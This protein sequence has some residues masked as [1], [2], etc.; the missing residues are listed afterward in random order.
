[1]QSELDASEHDRILRT[2]FSLVLWFDARGADAS[3]GNMVLSNLAAHAYV[4]LTY[5]SKWKELQINY[6]A[7]VTRSQFEVNI[8]IR[9]VLASGDNL[10]RFAAEQIPDTREV[11]SC[12]N[13]KMKGYLSSD[14]V[15]WL[16][17]EAAES[18]TL[19]REHPEFRNRLDLRSIAH[20]HGCGDEWD[21]FYT[22]YSKILHP[23]AWLLGGLSVKCDL[24]SLKQCLTI[25]GLEYAESSY[26]LI[27]DR[28][29][30]S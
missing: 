2:F 11:F 3:Q 19:L 24:N 15:N 17:A 5:Y 16:A 6:L 28:M 14:F 25:K 4:L 10:K 20:E 30:F 12:L 23:T 21:T 9:Y 18:Q 27:A 29:K 22:L 8:W 1:M 7:W 13:E 26:Q